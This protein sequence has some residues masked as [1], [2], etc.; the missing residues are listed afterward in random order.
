MFS[1]IWRVAGLINQKKPINQHYYLIN[2]LT[3]Q[4]CVDTDTGYLTVS[5]DTASTQSYQNNQHY[6]ISRIKHKG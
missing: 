5:S 3:T 4:T 2:P 1:L 6:I